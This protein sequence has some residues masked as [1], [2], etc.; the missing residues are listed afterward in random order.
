MIEKSLRKVVFVSD[1][2]VSLSPKVLRQ[3]EKDIRI[4]QLVATYGSRDV[5]GSR[6]QFTG[7]LL[8]D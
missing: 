6:F 1:F 7:L 3:D 5:G 4:T 2:F 8:A